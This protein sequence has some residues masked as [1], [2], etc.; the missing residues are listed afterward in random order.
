M[1]SFRLTTQTNKDVADTTFKYFNG[2]AIFIAAVTAIF[3]ALL[4]LFVNLDLYLNDS[5]F[6]SSLG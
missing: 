2:T 3:T 6:M 4:V 1:L 5:E